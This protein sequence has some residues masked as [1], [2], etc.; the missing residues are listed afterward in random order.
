MVAPPTM[1]RTKRCACC[2]QLRPVA[3]FG[4]NRQAKD[5]L[6]YYCKKCAASRQ[7]KWSRDNPEKVQSM[8]TNYLDRIREQNAARDPYE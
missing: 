7:R 1:V 5:G 8:R 2:K 4:K 3:C 6:H